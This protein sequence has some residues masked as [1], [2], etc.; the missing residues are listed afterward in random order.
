MQSCRGTLRRRGLAAA[1]LIACLIAAPAADASTGRFPSRPFSPRSFWNARLADD[2]PIDAQS[3]T[4]VAELN[5]QRTQWLPWINTVRYSSPVYTVPRSQPV[6]RVQL[7]NVQRDLQAAW[8]RVPIPA[9]AQPAAGTDGTMVVVQPATDTMWE[10]WGAERRSDGW[11]ARYGGRIRSMSSN[12]GYY[13]DP[14]E[15]GATATSIPM[16]GGLIRVDELRRGR[17]GHGLAIAI[18]QPRKDVF[19]WPAQRTDG[20]YDNADAIP[21]GTRFRIDPRVNLDELRMSPV[22]RMMAEAVQDYGM[23]VRD[24]AG[25]VAFYAEDPTPLG[26]D[27]YA[28]STGFFDNRYPSALLADFPWQYLQALRTQQRVRGRAAAVRRR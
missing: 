2:A 10:F 9:D 5:R 26:A 15:W 21:E 14:P 22:V 3:R 13:T 19:S 6:V 1:A 12:P 11:H 28:G 20:T 18:P 17:I 8:E 24:K 25:S 23:V 7:D 16:L 4:Y 27:P